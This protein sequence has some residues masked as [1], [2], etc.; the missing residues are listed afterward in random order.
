MSSSSMEILEEK[1]VEVDS[2]KK[3]KG[4][5]PKTRKKRSK[6]WIDFKEQKL[7]KGEL[8]EDVKAKCLHCGDLYLCHTKKYG[9]TNLQNHLGRGKPYL[10]KII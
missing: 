5:Q 7:K 4:K 9:I 10:E 2:G 6:V 1:L 8:P 3:K